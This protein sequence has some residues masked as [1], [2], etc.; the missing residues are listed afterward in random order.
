MSSSRQS[1]VRLSGLS[2]PP[3][4]YS[5]AASGSATRLGVPPGQPS[6][7]AGTAA[8]HVPPVT[9]KEALLAKF[10][11]YDNAHVYKDVY[12]YAVDEN[13]LNFVVQF[14]D[15]NAQVAYG[16]G[17]GDVRQLLQQPSEALVDGTAPIRWM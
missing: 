2:R 17:E 4:V 6:L 12:D 8:S 1:G 11:N 13:A 15:N 16:L 9:P 14:G 3:P 10:R 5:A 7:S